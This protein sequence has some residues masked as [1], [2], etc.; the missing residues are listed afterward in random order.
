MNSGWPA[1]GRNWRDEYYRIGLDQIT[2]RAFVQLTFSP[3]P[4]LVE[5]KPPPGHQAWREYIGQAFDPE[6]FDLVPNLWDHQ[7]CIV[8]DFTINP[9]HTYWRNGQD[10]IVCDVCHEYVEAS[11]SESSG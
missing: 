4:A 11:M 5:K 9:G 1:D 10:L 6:E 3:G 7:H 2:D 8:C